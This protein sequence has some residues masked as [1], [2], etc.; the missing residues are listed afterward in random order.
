LRHVFLYE[1]TVRALF[2]S[3][4]FAL[5]ALAFLCGILEGLESLQGISNQSSGRLQFLQAP[6]DGESFKNC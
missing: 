1:R 6:C 2:N 4:R 5:F 3:F